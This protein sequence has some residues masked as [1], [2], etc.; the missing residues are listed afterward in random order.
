[1]NS[2]VY[3]K[4]KRIVL[5]DSLRGFALMGLFMVHMFEYF[6]LYWYKP[7]ASI[8][9]DIT[10]FLFGG[11]AYAVFAMLFGVSFFII[12]DNQANRGVDFRRKFAWRLFILF[13]FGLL[14]G[15]IYGGDILQILAITGF[16]L[17]PI[18]N[19]RNSILLFYA[20]IFL[21]QI[22]MLMYNF[23]FVNVGELGNPNHW[24][25][26]GPVFET[27]AK[28]SFTDLI[29]VTI[30]K[31]QL[32]KWAFMIESGRLSTIIGISIF[33]FLLGRVNFFRRISEFK[34]KIISSFIFLFIL[35]SVI[36]FW[37]EELFVLL[38]ENNN[39]IISAVLNSYINLI[40]TF[41]GLAGFVLIY[42]LHFFEKL[43]SFLAPCGKM[44]LTIYVMQSIIFVPFFYGFGFG[45]Y[46]TIGQTLSFFLG[47]AFWLL[48]VVLAH[49]W[50][51]QFYFGPLEWLWRTLTYF[52]WDIEFKKWKGNEILQIGKP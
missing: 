24:A 32:A 47:I 44:S 9:N 28:G 45:F 3:V 20:L 41:A 49:V 5:V 39:W 43:L 50:T 37:R 35:G 11:K 19:S 51:K 16:L 2:S 23:F 38:N 30:W 8:F 34:T 18:Y 13:L 21:L 10:F 15:L 42:Q 26:Y 25:L 12:M 31:S 17:I 14:H 36:I 48:Q 52:K 27:Y 29:S 6:E 4:A 7:E 33:G 46:E 1:M 22:P 40:L